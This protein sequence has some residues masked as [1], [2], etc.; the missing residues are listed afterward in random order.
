MTTQ[1]G[2]GTKGLLPLK[3]DRK[4]FTKIGQGFRYDIAWADGKILA[5]FLTPEQS[6]L[7]LTRINSFDAVTE[8]LRECVDYIEMTM[9]HKGCMNVEQIMESLENVR[10]Y[11]SSIETA[12]HLGCSQTTRR[13]DLANAR[14][15]LAAA[16]E[17]A[18]K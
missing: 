17:R 4:D 18:E 1:P 6:E 11:N 9:A 5:T 14:A 3:V 8:A 16:D 13:V 15:L 2:A 10:R 7:I 12:H